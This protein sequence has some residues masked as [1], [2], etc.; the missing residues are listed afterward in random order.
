MGTPLTYQFSGVHFLYFILPPILF[1]DGYNLKKKAFFRDIKL[2]LL[3]GTVGAIINFGMLVYANSFLIPWI[4][5][6]TNE[7]EAVIKF[8]TVHNMLSLSAAMCATKSVTSLMIVHHN[9][10]KLLGVIFGEAL[11]NDSLTIVMFRTISYMH[12]HE[13]LGDTSG[14]NVGMVGVSL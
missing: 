12:T 5:S 14:K 1:A 13:T 11:V 8:L 2:I 4:I 7:K 10:D 3:N 6:Y 9:A